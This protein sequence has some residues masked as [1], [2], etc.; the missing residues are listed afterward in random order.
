MMGGSNPGGT[1]EWRSDAWRF[2][3][4]QESWHQLPDLPDADAYGPVAFGANELLLFGDTAWSWNTV[5]G[6]WVDRGAAMLPQFASSAIVL[7]RGKLIQLTLEEGGSAPRIYAL[8]LPRPTAA[9][10]AIDLGVLVGYLA[11]LIGL[12]IW[13][14]RRERST[15]DFFL[16]GQRIPWWAAGISLFAT[17]L[18]AITFLGTPAVSYATDWMLLPSWLGILFF[19]PLAVKV[20]LPLYRRRPMRTVYTWLE[21]RFGVSVRLFGSFSFLVFQ[22]LRMGVVVYLPS[23]AL[24]TA[25]GVEVW[26]CVLLMGVLATIYTVLGGMEAVIWTDVLQTGVLLLA[27][28]ATLWVVFAA[29]GDPIAALATAADAGK[30]RTFGGGWSTVEAATWALLLGGFFLQFGPYTADQAMV[31]RYLTTKDEK[32][33]ARGIWLNGWMSVPAGALFILVGTALWLYYRARPEALDLG[34]ETDAVFPLFL[35]KELPTG[36]SGLVIA[37]LF[38]AAMSTLDSGMHAVATTCTTDWYE[39]LSGRVASLRQARVATFV[40]GAVATAIALLLAASGI[41]SSLLFFLK[42]LGLLTS[43]VA[44]VFLLGVM[45]KRAHSAGALTGAAV[46]ISVL[47]W[48]VFTTD[49][50][51]FVYPLIGIPATVIAGWLASRLIPTRPT[52][53]S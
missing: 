48:V 47:A 46:G 14:S 27:V 24:S 42:A 9:L 40:A 34:V 20:F 25:T 44:G 43:G 41:L 39:R 8:S 1:P 29:V 32:A 35:A 15:E 23:L 36:V 33:A 37:G 4:Q 45:S 10:G 16:A 7:W 5:T 52:T 12:G 38:A 22:L 50:Y 30:L 21:W 28:A 2:D 13:F 51:L 31:Q 26:Q 6:T 19:A 49:T 17:Q 3:F 53:V 11:L 18:S